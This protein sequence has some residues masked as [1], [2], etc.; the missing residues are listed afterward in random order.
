MLK[1]NAANTTAGK[2]REAALLNIT[3][4]IFKKTGLILKK[5]KREKSGGL[6]HCPAF[7]QDVHGCA[8]CSQ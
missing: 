7:P 8:E 4:K 3:T 6:A 2:V 5:R 1:V